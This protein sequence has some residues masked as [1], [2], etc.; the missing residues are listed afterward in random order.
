MTIIKQVSGRNLVKPLP[1]TDFVGILALRNTYA[2]HSSQQLKRE[3]SMK[4]NQ[5]ISLRIEPELKRKIVRAAKK[6]DVTVG[7]YIR[8]IIIAHVVN[9]SD[10]P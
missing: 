7:A 10:K 4:K 3:A 8:G 6:E 5:S 2:L 1:S 9:R